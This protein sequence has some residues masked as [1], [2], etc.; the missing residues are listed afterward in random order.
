VLGVLTFFLPFVD[1]KG[2]LT[3]AVIAL[4]LFTIVVLLS[5]Y[6]LL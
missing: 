1:P 4:L 2:S 3:T 6:A 5:G